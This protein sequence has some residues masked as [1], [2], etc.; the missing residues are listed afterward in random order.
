MKLPI[1]IE[2]FGHI[3]QLLSA[4]G[5]NHNYAYSEFDFN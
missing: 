5:V 4:V 1:T 2:D 3:A